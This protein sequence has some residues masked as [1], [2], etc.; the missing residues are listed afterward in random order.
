MD[1][2][3]MGGGIA[4]YARTER[5]H[6]RTV[7]DRMYS[8][9]VQGRAVDDAAMNDGTASSSVVADKHWAVARGEERGAR[10][11]DW[12]ILGAFHCPLS[13]QTA[14]GWSIRGFP[15]Y[16]LAKIDTL[17][18]NAAPHRQNGAKVSKQDL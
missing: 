10:S 11:D 4:G 15:P 12:E 6:T 7:R 9:N 3:G 2:L 18:Y 14:S 1:I 5:Y 8:S 17:H 13:L 16:N